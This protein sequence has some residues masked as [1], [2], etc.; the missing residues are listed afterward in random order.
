[1]KIINRKTTLIQF[2]MQNELTSEAGNSNIKLVFN[3]YTFYIF[4]F[5]LVKF[6]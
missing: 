6:I 4:N 2:K 3:N 5:T 1:M